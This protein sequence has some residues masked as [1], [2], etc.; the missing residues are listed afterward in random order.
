MAV[1]IEDV[2]A[3]VDGELD[4]QQANTVA[5]AVSK[6]ADLRQ[7]ADA[8]RA[9]QLPFGDA[10]SET[11]IPDVPDSLRR[12]IE[13]LQTTTAQISANIATQGA[14]NTNDSAENA[15][16][17]DAEN[18]HAVTSADTVTS[19]NAEEKP[20]FKMVGIAASVMVAGL[21]GFFAGSNLNNDATAPD[22]SE[23]VAANKPPVNALPNPENFVRTVTAYQTLYSRDTRIG[24]DNSPDTVAALTERLSSQTGMDIVIPKLEGYEFVRAQHLE[25]GDKPLLQLVYL[26]EEG[27]PLALCFM[28]SQ[29]DGGGEDVKLGHYYGLNTAEWKQNDRRIVMVSD[30]PEETMTELAKA[31]R[32]QWSI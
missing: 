28:P 8:M 6:N 13:S 26:G 4:A 25:Y 21:I 12:K 23:T 10:Y 27:V 14:A 17:V 22:V 24:S 15:N 32:Q 5:N 16:E 29:L 30:A 9:S 11:P 7:A 1:E 20:P 3:W 18:T 19:A 2:R 31:A